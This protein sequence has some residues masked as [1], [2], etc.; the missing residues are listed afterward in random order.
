[1]LRIT[2]IAVFALLLAACAP[3]KKPLPTVQESHELVVVTYNNPATYYVNG[4]NDFAGLEYDL[5]RLFAKEL[6]PDI[7][8]KF[9]VVG[10]VEEVI[11][12]LLKGKAHI[13]AAGLGMTRLRNYLVRFGPTYQ[14]VQPQ[15]VVNREKAE[16]PSKVSELEGM[17]LEVPFGSSCAENLSEIA[18]QLPSLKWRGV[19]KAG[20]DELLEK[21]ADGT[22]DATIADSHLVSIVQN[23]YPNLE[24]AFDFGLTQKLAWAFPKT[25][26]EWVY[27]KSKQFFE[28][29]QKDGT[30]RNLLDRYYG[31]SERLNAMDV[32]NFL[33]NTRTLLP[34][35]LNLFRQ[36]QETTGVDWRLLAAISYQESHWDTYSTSPTNVRGLMMLTE[37][38][39]DKLGVSDR[40]DPKQS[41]P[42]GARYVLMLKD[43][44]PTRIPEPDRTWLALAAYNIG[45]AHLEDARV[46]AQRQKLNP[47]SWADLKKTLPLLNKAE[48]YS[49]VKNGFARGGAPVVFVESVRTYYRILEKYEEKHTPV[50]PK[51]NVAWYQR[52]MTAFP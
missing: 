1:M 38:T 48:Y 29:I 35:Y 34:K 15:V 46:L 32:T 41:I 30:L 39:A 13:A 10:G 36:A 42:A 20:S 51:F 31:H 47:D 7:K 49:T 19:R 43:E 14:E 18:T 40:L 45:I 26:E 52:R 37:N 23:Y 27:Q 6:G 21:V 16:K 9:V 24:V 12:A 11:P 5:V 8:V 2:L 3:A 4:N 50:L 44:I 22:L 17:S 25:G 33:I 28:R